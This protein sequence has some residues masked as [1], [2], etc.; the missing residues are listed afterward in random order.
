MKRKTLLLALLFFISPLF[1]MAQEE[2]SP[3]ETPAPVHERVREFK[4]FFELN[5]QEEQKL[6]QKL[7]AELQKNFAEL[8][9]YDTE[10]YFEL[11]ME[12]QYR[13]MR[14]PFATKKE[15]EMLQREKKIFELEVAT[16]SLSSK[17]NSDKS[18]D[19]SKLKSQ[20]T[21]TISELFDLKEL[22]RQSQ[23][24]ELERELAS[25]KKELDIR[26]KN[27]TEIIRRRVQELLG[28]DDYLDWD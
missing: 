25:L 15:K 22:N 6:L 16:R 20:L 21:S 4:H 28:E 5:E 9:K 3:P 19:K 8:K 10:E 27:K 23:V 2:P 26:S 7:N 24:K 12:S 11:L 14:Y 1:L 18:A 17:Y 13:N